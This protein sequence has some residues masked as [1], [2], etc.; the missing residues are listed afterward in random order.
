MCGFPLLA[1]LLGAFGSTQTKFAP[2]LVSPEVHADRTVTF[3]L[4][5]P[6]AHKV[7]VF[8]EGKAKGYEMTKN[9]DGVWSVTTEP[10]N[11]NYYGYSFDADDQACLDILNPLRKP[12]L[13]WQSNMVLVPGNPPEVWE[14][15]DVPHGDV[16]HH[17]YTSKVIGDKRDYYVYTPPDYPNGGPYPVLYLLH[18][19]SDAADGWTSVGMANTI[20][21]NLISEGK[22]KPMVIV[23]TLGYGIPDFASP[24]GQG[25][26]D[27][28]RVMRNYNNYRDALFNE[29]IP[30]V[31]SAY[32]VSTDRE[33]RAIAGLSMGGAETLYIG[34]NNLDR[35]AYIGSFSA[36]GLSREFDL[37]FP[38]LNPEAVNQKV[39]KLMVACGTS[40]GLI[41]YNR[42][43]KDW[44]R[45]LNV[46]FEDVE[47]PG[48]HEWPVWRRN[49][50]HFCQ[51]I[52]K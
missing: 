12:N 38:G 6:L 50:A 1:A 37:E 10:L 4:K 9:A 49:L 11:P 39:K 24:M 29:V 16:H 14:V 41:A 13:L 31:E 43:L 48:M 35:F 27:P 45:V 22:A 30:Q 23:M 32:K 33:S 40:D 36:G 2:P 25:F 52:F 17:L 19:Y 42:E 8:V 34:L 28:S 20:L 18:G 7:E 15:Q 26:R 44:L 21:D 3:R 5:M 47:T 51:E 46:S